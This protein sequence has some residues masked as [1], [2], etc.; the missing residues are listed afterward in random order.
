MISV[1][2]QQFLIAR[3]K[4]CGSEDGKMDT[5][6]HE[7]DARTP[8]ERAASKLDQIAQLVRQALMEHGIDVTVFF[9]VPSS[10]DA[11]VTFGTTGNPPDDL[12]ARISDLVN[13]VVKEAVGVGRLRCRHLVCA[14]TDG[15]LT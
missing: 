3:D 6:Q 5:R 7:D 2:V 13:A 10:G 15:A 1:F 12:W 9:V 14:G 8:R 11:I 4:Y